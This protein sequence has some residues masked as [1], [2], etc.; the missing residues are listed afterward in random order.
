[1]ISLA[2]SLCFEKGTTLFVGSWQGK[3][4][5]SISIRVFQELVIICSW[6]FREVTISVESGFPSLFMIMVHS[7]TL[8]E[9]LLQLYALGHLHN[10]FHGVNWLEIWFPLEQSLVPLDWRYRE[11]NGAIC[12]KGMKNVLQYNDHVE[13]G[14]YFYQSEK[15]GCEWPHTQPHH[16]ASMC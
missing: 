7:G 16:I 4:L 9:T 12:T 14:A 5:F 11:S 3:R 8:W 13:N 2:S 15:R 10:I 1:M 6:N